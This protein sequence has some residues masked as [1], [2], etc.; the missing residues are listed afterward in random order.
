MCYFV[1]LALL[2]SHILV[3]LLKETMGKL[4]SHPFNVSLLLHMCIWCKPL[5]FRFKMG[6]CQVDGNPCKVKS[7]VDNDPCEVKYCLFEPACDVVES[8]SLCSH[9][10]LITLNVDGMALIPVEK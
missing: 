3:Y 5:Q 9:E 10:S 2:S 8:H 4:Y 1:C 6:K 7:H